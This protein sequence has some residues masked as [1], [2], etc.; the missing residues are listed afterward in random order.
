MS[1]PFAIDLPVF[2]TDRLRLRGPRV[3]DFGPL[4]AYWRTERSRFEDG[5]KDRDGAWDDFATAFGCWLIRGYGPWCIEPL[6]GGPF[7]GTV[8]V[9]HPAWCIEPDLGWTLMAEAEGKG[10]AH[11]AALAARAWSYAHTPVGRL[12]SNIDRGNARSIRLATRLGAVE[13]PN[14][15]DTSPQTVIYRHP[16]RAAIL[17]ETP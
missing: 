14:A 8:G 15:P 9:F 6:G 16:D 12:T 4:E 3:E 10:Y 1:A 13:D 11:E 7:L 2:E 17:G 5:P